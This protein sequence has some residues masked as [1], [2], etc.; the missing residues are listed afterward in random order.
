[1]MIKS[2]S[3]QAHESLPEPSSAPLLDETQTAPAIASRLG[4]DT[5]APALSG[6]ERCNFYESRSRPCREQAAD[7]YYHR[8]VEAYFQFFIPPGASV[9]EIGCG[10]GDLLA[11]LK[12]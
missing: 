7:R 11:S 4:M 10:L 6:G 5:V 2:P 12:P 3:S 1:M 8:L 9:L